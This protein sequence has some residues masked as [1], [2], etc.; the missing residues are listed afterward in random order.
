M[1]SLL[2]NIRTWTDSEKALLM[3]LLIEI[4]WADDDFQAS[5]K[6]SLPY[7]IH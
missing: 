7:S 5:E 4:A 3:S 1:D 6:S 2:K